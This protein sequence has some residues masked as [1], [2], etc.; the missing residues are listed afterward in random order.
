[1]IVLNLKGETNDHLTVWMPQKHVAFVGDLIYRSFPNLYT[2]RGAPSRDVFQW[3]HSIGKIRSLNANFLIMSH[4]KPLV[5][6]SVIYDLLTI[7]RDAIQ[8]VHDQTVRY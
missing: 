8:F 6:K 1:M 7:Y 3:Y 2:L 5:G 4:T